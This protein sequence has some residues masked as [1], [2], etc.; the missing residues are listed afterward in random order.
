MDKTVIAYMDI[1]GYKDLVERC[2]TDTQIIKVIEQGLKDG[3]SRSDIF[4]LFKSDD[5]IRM[6]NQA[7]VSK[8]SYQMVS[9]VI[10]VSMPLSNLPFGF[11]CSFQFRVQLFS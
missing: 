10:L 2:Q 7:R 5:P 1:L 9:D 3:L 4:L 11:T 6:A 8:Q